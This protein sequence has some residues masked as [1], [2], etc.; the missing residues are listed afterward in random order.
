MMKA[1]KTPAANNSN[2]I[3]NWTKKPIIAKIQ[4]DTEPNINA[5]ILKALPEINVLIAYKHNIIG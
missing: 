4:Q 1:N 5:F 3:L 2:C